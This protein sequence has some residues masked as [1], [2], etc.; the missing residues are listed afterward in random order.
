MLTHQNINVNVDLTTKG[1]KQMKF[2]QE[3]IKHIEKDDT[4]ILCFNDNANLVNEVYTISSLASKGL[5]TLSDKTCKD[6]SFLE[7]E[8]SDSVYFRLLVDGRV[9]DDQKDSYE[10]IT[11]YDNFENAC[12]HLIDQGYIEDEDQEIEFTIEMYDFE[13]KID[14]PEAIYSFTEYYNYEHVKTEFEEHNLYYKGGV[15]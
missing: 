5:I 1:V 15:V 11:S 3:L 4:F 13:Q 8:L 6:S 9:V 12:L 7:F 10:E 2:D 14:K